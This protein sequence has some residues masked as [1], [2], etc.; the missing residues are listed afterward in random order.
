MK[1]IFS[2]CALFMVQQALLG[3]DH[4]SLQYE[5]NCALEKINAISLEPDPNLST[6]LTNFSKTAGLVGGGATA[7]L[8]AYYCYNNVSNCSEHVV[9]AAKV[10][11]NGL[12]G[13]GLS[14]LAGHYLYKGYMNRQKDLTQNLINWYID[15]HNTAINA[16]MNVKM[17]TEER[18]QLYQL[19]SKSNILKADHRKD[20]HESQFIKDEK[21]DF[22][23]LHAIE[24]LKIKSGRLESEGEAAKNITPD[25]SLIDLNNF[26][27]ADKG[28]VTAIQKQIKKDKDYILEQ[29][30]IL[31][32]INEWLKA[33][34]R[35]ANEAHYEKSM[36]EPSKLQE[37]K[38]QLT[39]IKSELESLNACKNINQSFKIATSKLTKKKLQEAREL[40]ETCSVACPGKIDPVVI[41]WM[42]KRGHSFEG[43]TSKKKIGSWEEVESCL[44]EIT[45][46]ASQNSSKK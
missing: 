31:P 38:Q 25:W 17:N 20:V 8:S 14:Y 39:K 16:H 45:H 44:N 15:D 5:N 36:K 6:K 21:N 34:F 35:Y 3:A 10:G 12:L 28:K 4:K 7:L 9:T 24:C 43:T 37:V 29:N 33:I 46:I 1:K 32:K 27:P 42:K 19:L 13:G 2:L 40:Y 26:S 30:K 22:P 23:V 18:S 11:I 41:E